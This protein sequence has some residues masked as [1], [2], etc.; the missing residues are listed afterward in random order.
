MSELIRLHTVCGCTRDLAVPKPL[1]EYRVPFLLGRHALWV[2][3][4]DN[5]TRPFIGQRVFERGSAD[6]SGLVHFH[7]V[8]N[9][10]TL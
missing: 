2:E 5:M 1:Y 10:R 3:E 8:I 6:A 9:A 4:S 7:E